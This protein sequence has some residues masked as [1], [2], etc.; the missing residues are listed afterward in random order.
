MFHRIRNSKGHSSAN[1]GRQNG[2]DARHADSLWHLIHTKE[3]SR[4]TRCVQNVGQPSVVDVVDQEV[5]ELEEI[6]QLLRAAW[7]DPAEKARLEIGAQEAFTPTHNLLMATIESNVTEAREQLSS[8]ALSRFPLFKP[9]SLGRNPAWRWASVT[10]VLMTTAL[11]SHSIGYYHALRALS[12]PAASSENALPSSIIATSP[13]L[14]VL[15]VQSLVNDFD[16]SLRRQTP[17]E[18]VADERES[19]QM[20]GHKLQNQL[21][22]AMHLPIKP[23]SGAKLLGARRHS[24]WNRTGVQ[25]HY[26]KDGVRIAVYQFREP[27]CGMGDL[28]EV[29]WKGQLFLT[30]QRGAYRI[31]VW[32]ED[33]DVM[34]M[35]SPLAMRQHESLLLAEDI[36]QTN[37]FA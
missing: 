12:S 3:K 5:Q 18:F 28:N 25:V 15:P 32:R 19:T 8:R 9:L 30:G 26:V 29:E 27:S 1:A 10:A 2:Q 4:S 22:V 37:D 24:A 13:N 31:V 20:I 11:G 33:D 21:G 36:R 6:S 16:V 7:D 35:V 23:R 34:A 14:R 17:L